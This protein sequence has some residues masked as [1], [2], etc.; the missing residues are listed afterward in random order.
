LAQ[1]A[2]TA[3]VWLCYTQW[4]WKSVREAEITVKGLNAAFG[5]D[6]SVFSLLNIEMLRKFKVGSVMAL[7]AW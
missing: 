6:T 7:L 3:T 5:A 4:L 1:I 2:L